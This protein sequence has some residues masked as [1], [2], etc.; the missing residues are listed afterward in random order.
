MQQKFDSNRITMLQA[1]STTLLSILGLL[2]F[3]IYILNTVDSSLKNSLGITKLIIKLVQLPWHYLVL[4]LFAL[5]L[6]SYCI[7]YFLLKNSKINK[8]DKLQNG[9]ND[10]LTKEE[11]PPTKEMKR[12]IKLFK[13][14]NHVSCKILTTELKYS[15][16]KADHYI[17][18]L[19]N[20]NYIKLNQSL[21]FRNFILMYYLVSND[22]Y[23]SITDIG[24]EYAVNYNLV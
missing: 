5:I 3:V 8:N 18:L 24:R 21:I 19:V 2:T 10:S 9:N 22:L 16:V 13:K 12:I 20:S 7:P 15:A 14:Y 1:T 23:Y 11:L 4:M 6:L 17:E